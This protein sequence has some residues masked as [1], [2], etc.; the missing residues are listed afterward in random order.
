MFKEQCSGKIGTR[1]FIPHRL[2]DNKNAALVTP[3]NFTRISAC[4]Q[5]LKFLHSAACIL[6]ISFF[7]VEF[8]VD[9]PL[10]IQSFD[11]GIFLG[12]KFSTGNA[13]AYISTWSMVAIFSREIDLSVKII[14]REARMIWAIHWPFFFFGAYHKDESNNYMI[15]RPSD[16]CQAI[17]RWTYDHLS[18]HLPRT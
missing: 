14:K 9:V 16:V 8:I 3:G 4:W 18:M 15:G 1:V 13:M 5:E 12:K 11:A 17:S 7:R 10:R 6:A 2:R